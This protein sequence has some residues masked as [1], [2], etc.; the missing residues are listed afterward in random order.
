[1]F[2]KTTLMLAGNIIKKVFVFPI[3]NMKFSSVFLLYSWTEH[4]YGQL[5]IEKQLQITF[6]LHEAI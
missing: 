6:P 5:I 2:Y 4:S 1:M 3:G